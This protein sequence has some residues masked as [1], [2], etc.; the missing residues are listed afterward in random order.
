MINSLY[1]H[2]PFCNS[3]CYYCDFTK[4]IYKK[5][6]VSEYLEALKEDLK[7]FS[8]T[9]LKTIY[10][11]GG[12][13]TSLSLDELEIL[14]KTLEPYSKDVKEYTFEANVESLTKEKLLLLRKYNVNRL[15]IGVQTFNDKLLKFI[16]R[17]HTSEDVIKTINL[18]K[19]LSFNNISID[20]IYGL[21]FQ[22]LEDVKSD[23]TRALSLPIT[24]I[25]TYSL[26]INPSTIASA[27][28]W[29]NQDSDNEAQ[30]FNLIREQLE[31]AGFFQYEV[32]NFAKK[33][34]KSLHNLTYWHNEEYYAVGYGAS[35][36]VNKVRYTNNGSFK[37]YLNKE[38]IRESEEITPELFKEEYLML[39]LRLK[40]GFSLD[41]YF[42]KT[43]EKFNLE[44]PK[45]KHFLKTNLLIYENN[46]LYCSPEGLLK[47]DYILSY[48]I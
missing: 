1:V 46:R 26:L 44:H 19:N 3:I 40:E 28:G 5:E 48:I 33:G 30:M 17:K 43:G 4:V 15:S 35:G 36:Y 34:F 41:D 13:P 22:T 29:K 16:G 9:N 32:S 20:L 23:V 37:S 39:H 2:I 27:R 38:F 10:V 12:T 42:K 7:R 18:A 11:G 6:W 25:S 31:D 24:H 47:L 8:I 45:I 21:P 14:L